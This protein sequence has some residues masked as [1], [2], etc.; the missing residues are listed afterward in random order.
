MND[1][2]LCLPHL[3]PPYNKYHGNLKCKICHGSGFY[4]VPLYPIGG[5][6]RKGYYSCLECNPESFGFQHEKRWGSPPKLQ[7]I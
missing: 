5:D 6:I 7:K 2:T 3:S 1:K 4:V